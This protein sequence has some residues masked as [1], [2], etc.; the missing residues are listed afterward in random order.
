MNRTCPLLFLVFLCCF[1]RSTG[2]QTNP[3]I[4]GKYNWF[5]FYWE[6]NTIAGQHFDKAAILIPIQMNDFK[7]YN[8]AQ[9]DLGSNATILY[10]NT[11]KNYFGSRDWLR[12]KDRA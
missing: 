8:V 11:I 2:Q 7:G 3:A 10:G 4:D 1:F 6:G 5:T 12:Q 9:F